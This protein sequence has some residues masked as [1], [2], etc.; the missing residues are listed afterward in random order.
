[1]NH[2]RGS[3][4][5]ARTPLLA[6]CCILSTVALAACRDKQP[7]HL[8]P[9]ASAVASVAVST[10]AAAFRVDTAT[11]KVSF[12]MEAPIE[13]IV[14]EAPSSVSGELFVDFDD[15]QKSTA[16]VTVD[17]DQLS[18][19][20][21]KRDDEKGQFS[22]RSKNATQN[23]HARTWLEISP[24]TPTDLREKHRF[25]E[26]RITRLEGLSAPSFKALTGAER[27]LTATAIGELRLHGRS[28]P[29][30]A[31]IELTARYEGE[32]PKELRVKT[33]SPLNAGLEEYDVRPRE[34]FGKLAQRTLDALGSKV[35]KTAPIEVELTARPR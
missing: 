28:S 18:L 30:T 20:Q 3:L 13:K 26:Y 23:E 29:K 22:E 2:R 25:A 9:V 14:G 15:V 11:S 21:Q 4:N 17:L 34:A 24:D 7:E 35:A 6:A 5:T 8:A 10:A 1:M 31:K 12:L 19:Y 16:Q 32:Q 33:L 27:T